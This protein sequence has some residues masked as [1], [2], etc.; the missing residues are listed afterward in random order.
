MSVIDPIADLLTRIR[1]AYKA[2]H[3]TVSIT[4]SRTREA[5][6]KIL[7][8]EG[9]INGYALENDALLVNLKYHENKAVVA[10]LKRISK[11]GRRIYVGAKSIPSVQNG[12][13]IC[14]LSTSKGVL[15]GKQAA[16]IGVGGELLCEIW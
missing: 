14:I 8:E 2:M 6:L 13:G 4:P 11:P 16:E 12:L 5:L 7:N 10:G 15:E 9:Y 3:S 1:N